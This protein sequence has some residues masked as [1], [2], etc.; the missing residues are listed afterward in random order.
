MTNLQLLILCATGLIAGIGSGLFGIGGGVIIVP[1][2]YFVYG[3]EMKTASATSLVAMILPVG[4]LGVWQYFKA[5]IIN[6]THFKMGLM[7]SAGMFF[8]ALIGSKLSIVLSSKILSKAFSVFLIYVAIR[9][10]IQSSK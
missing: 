1:L 5:G 9:L 10:W 8:G 4:I 2:L 3:L 7:I 6:Q